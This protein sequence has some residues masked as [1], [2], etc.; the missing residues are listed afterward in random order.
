MKARRFGTL[1]GLVILG[2]VLWTLTPHFLT[3]SN[4]LNIV[5][6]IASSV[7]VAVMSVVLTAHLDHVVR[8]R[9]GRFGELLL[10]EATEESGIDGLKLD[11]EPIDVHIHPVRC[12]PADGE[13]TRGFR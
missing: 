4:L 5:Q 7:G 6:Q 10:R 11:P 13:P 12:R 9:Q 2:A 8:G 3:V 1:I